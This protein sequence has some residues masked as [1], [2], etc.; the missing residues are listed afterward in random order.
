MI[1]TGKDSK[2]NIPTLDEALSWLNYQGPLKL[3]SGYIYQLNTSILNQSKC[4]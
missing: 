3:V 2:Y 4:T 1:E